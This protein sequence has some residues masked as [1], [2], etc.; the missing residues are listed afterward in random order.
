MSRTLTSG[1]TTE[2]GKAVTLPGYFIEILFSTPLRLSSRATLTWSGNTWIT[3]DARI[4]GLSA[5]A[6][7]S[8]QDGKIVLGDTDNSI[9]ALVLSEGV[10]GRAINI[11]KFYGDAPGP[12]DP[13]AIFAGVGDKTSIEPDDGRLS[14]TLAQQG[15]NT[16]FSPRRYITKAEGF[17]IVPAEGA[18][19]TWNGET[20]RL[21]REGS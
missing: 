17:S 9:T 16:L 11:W 19:L 14:I 18:L 1:T 7:S 5:D 4:E 21:T 13:V 15:G 12:T 3:W 10:A 6:G 20:I 8:T 2:I